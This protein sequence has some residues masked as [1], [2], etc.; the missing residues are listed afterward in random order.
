M[1]PVRLYCGFG[2]PPCV[3]AS[4]I[5][6]PE[7]TAPEGSLIVPERLPVDWAKRKGQRGAP[8]RGVSRRMAMIYFAVAPHKPPA[9]GVTAQFGRIPTVG[10]AN[11]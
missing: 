6:T 1:R 10:V 7:K 8:Q 2:C 9:G 5:V 11:R 4:V 3:A